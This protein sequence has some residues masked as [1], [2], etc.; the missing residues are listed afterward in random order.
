MASEK[1]ILY[2]INKW[3][4]GLTDELRDTRPGVH[5]DMTE[6]D[7]FE[8]KS[9]VRPTT[10]LGD[11]AVI[12]GRVTGYDLDDQD[13][14]YAHSIDAGGTAITIYKKA[15][16][17]ANAPAAWASYIT[18]TGGSRQTPLKWHQYKVAVTSIARAT[19]TATITTVDPHGLVTGDVVVIK[20]ATES[21]F[22]GT[23]TLLSGSGSTLTYTVADS[24]SSS[25]NPTDAEITV[26]YLYFAKPAGLVRAIAPTVG[27]AVVATAR[28]STTMVL[29]GYSTES[30]RIFMTRAYNELFI[31]CGQYISAVNSAGTWTQKAFTL[32]DGWTAVSADLSGQ[33]LGILA[34]NNRKGYN[35]SKIFYW[36]LVYVAEDTTGQTTSFVDEVSIPMGGAQIVFN[37]KGLLWA[38]CAQNNVLNLYKVNGSV[39]ERFITLDN[40]PNES[41]TVGSTL[42]PTGI[43]PDA[44]KF[45]FEDTVMFG[46]LRTE[47]SGLYQLGQFDPASPFALVLA[48]K[49]RSTTADSTDKPYAAIAAG[50]NIYASHVT[51]NG[52]TFSTSNEKVKKLEN[53]NT[54]TFSSAAR[55]DTVFI[56]GGKPELV[57]EWIGF[58]AT[59]K[60]LPTSCSISV[61]SFLDDMTA[62]TTPTAETLAVST[63]QDV[64]P[65]TS[66]VSSIAGITTYF[67]RTITN[68]LGRE[69]KMRIVFTSNGSTGRPT[70]IMIAPISSE[71]YLHG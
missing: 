35:Q 43:V 12:A 4:G 21:N 36:D 24:G 15:T 39:A 34:K 47:K 44:S 16:A 64:Y 10:I 69:L 65:D 7:I 50:P 57:K 3:F 63:T 46:V 37:Y 53:N 19:T 8:D 41:D 40:I 60:T 6:V 13:N 23:K 26:S 27:S 48:K 62:S 1:N 54:P 25:E 18:S 9:L 68:L 14:A 31:G 51:G 61:Y 70:L 42:I 30:D 52:E 55:I 22:N 59:T 32:P 66:L 28:N 56:D 5:F 45:Y 2:R 49:F 38:I 29:P 71:G 67:R 33:F 17:S 11:D 20:F 58:I